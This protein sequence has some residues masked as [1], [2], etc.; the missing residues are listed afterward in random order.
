MSHSRTTNPS[1]PND[2][3]KQTPTTNPSK[4][5]DQSKQTP[6]TNPSKPQRP[7]QA[8]PTTNPT[9]ANPNDGPPESKRQ[10]QNTMYGLRMLE[11]AHIPPHYASL[12]IRWQLKVPHDASTP[13]L[14]MGA[15][16]SPSTSDAYY[17]HASQLL[18]AMQPRINFH[19]ATILYATLSKSSTAVS[20]H[21][22]YLFVHLF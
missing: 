8:N 19:D 20:L 9:T 11:V 22:C 14:L 17:N 13:Q 10:G 18:D 21:D 1:K 6:T 5:N 2:Q 3:S 7:I 4:P 15:M 16:Q 12:W